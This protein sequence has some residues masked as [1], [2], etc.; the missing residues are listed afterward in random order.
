MEMFGDSSVTVDIFHQKLAVLKEVTLVLQHLQETIPN[1][2]EQSNSDDESMIAEDMNG[3]N[4]GG[5]ARLIN[6]FMRWLKDIIHQVC[7]LFTTSSL[8]FCQPVIDLLHAVLCSSQRHAAAKKHR[9][10]EALCGFVLE[11]L[12]PAFVRAVG[13][14]DVSLGDCQCGF[15]EDVLVTPRS[16]QSVVPLLLECLSTLLNGGETVLLSYALNFRVPGTSS[17]SYAVCC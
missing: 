12:V 5:T 6:S 4:R 10:E 7:V 1:D 16:F 17:L 14:Y 11:H 13:S 8:G 15:I 9:G 2:K 3:I